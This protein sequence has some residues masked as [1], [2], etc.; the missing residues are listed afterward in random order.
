MNFSYLSI[1]LPFV[2]GCVHICSEVCM[3][4]CH[5][6]PSA[7][8]LSTLAFLFNNSRLK[9]KLVFFVYFTV[10]KIKTKLTDL[11]YYCVFGSFIMGFIRH[12]TA[13]KSMSTFLELQSWKML[14]NTFTRPMDNLKK[15]NKA[16]LI[17]AITITPLSQWVAILLTI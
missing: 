7:V 4:L 16:W 12:Y 8:I 2:I 11:Q 10:I 6:R 15:R 1:L 9:Y 17:L 13:I 14:T 5:L 3:L